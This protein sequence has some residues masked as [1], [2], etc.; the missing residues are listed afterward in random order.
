MI[1]ASTKR[2]TKLLLTAG[3]QAAAQGAV[4]AALS[5]KLLPFAGAAGLVLRLFRGGNTEN[6]PAAGKRPGALRSREKRS[7][8][9]VR[10]HRE[11][12]G[13]SHE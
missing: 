11:Q 1:N 13:H 6:R 4:R 9:A 7:A 5:N 3:A 8:G 2:S 10:H 12:G